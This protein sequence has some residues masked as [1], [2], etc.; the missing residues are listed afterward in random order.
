[1]NIFG[2]FF[3][4]TTFGES[5]GSGVGCVVDGCPSGLELTREDI[6]RELDRRRPG[7]SSIASDRMELDKVEILSGVFE[8]KTLGTPISLFI[9]NVDVDSSK[10]EELRNIPRPGHG[11]YTWKMK[12]G[13]VDWRGG[14]RSSGRETVGRVAGGAVALKLLQRSGVEVIAYS[15]EIAGI[16]GSGIEIRDVVKSRK[17]VDSNPVK[18]LDLERA[19]EMEEAVSAAKKEGDSVGGVVEAVVF[20]IPPG[21]G[22][23]VFGRLDADLASA[24]MSIP[25]VKGVE[26][27]GGFRLAGL[28]GSEV[29]DSF[30]VEDGRV[31]T[32][33]NNCGGVLGGISDGM[34][35]VV[36]VAVKPTSSIGRKQKTVDLKSMKETSVEIKGRHDP[37]IVPRAVPVV[38]AMVSLVLA[39][40]SLV[41]G[42]IPRKLV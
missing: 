1:M 15:K 16:Q 36:R 25:S 6:Q 38:E 8:G 21:L 7:R 3:R 23:P 14:G 5:H 9:G 39:D 28:R 22:E 18:A 26:F 19:G 4:L 12:F 27:G 2:R 20:G 37:C 33:T 17:V 13:W 10:Y 32:E 24:L 35:I 31:V 34:P 40:H 29:N 11:D 41:S 30:I 42:F